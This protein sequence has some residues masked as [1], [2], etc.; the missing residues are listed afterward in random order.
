MNER[1]TELL[2]ITREFLKGCTCAPVG[3][4][5]EC[6]ECTEA[7]VE[8]AY[9]SEMKHGAKHG[10]GSGGLDHNAIPFEKD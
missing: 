1:D 10:P 7:F 8:A 2:R 6:S 4:P 3:K 9:A 5:H